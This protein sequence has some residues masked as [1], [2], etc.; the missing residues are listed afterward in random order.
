MFE[1]PTLYVGVSQRVVATLVA[2]ALVLFTVGYHASAQAAN[3][4]NISDTLSTSE[5]SV[6]SAHTVA[7]TIP[8]TSALGTGDTITISF[9]AN[10]TDVN[11][12]VGGDVTLTVN[13]GAATFSGFVAAADNISFTSDT[14]AVAGEEIVVA[15]ADG[16][17]V[18]PALISSFEISVDTGTGGDSGNTR[19]AVVDTVLVTA[20]VPTTLNFIITGTATGTVANGDATTGSTTATT[21]PFGEL[22]TT[23]ATSEVLAQHLSVSTNARNGFVVT[24]EQDDN[25]QSSTGAIIDSFTD[26]TFVD[27]PIAWALPGGGTPTIGDD[28]TWGHW[29]L[30]SSDADL[31]GNEFGTSLYI[32]ASTTPRIIFSHA[33]SSDGVT[34]FIGSTTVGYRIQISPLQEAG[35]DYQAILTYIATPT[36]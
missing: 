35:D 9:D 3:L 8:P 12:V 36:F 13:G 31:N 6:T 17:I 29:G 2:C 22:D 33:S 28:T 11:T 27:S 30:T 19:V 14:A 25:L 34:D 7:F 18:N 23:G 21:I 26:G 32:A 1:K 24:V 10:F 20:I 16:K 15:I 4:L 5:P